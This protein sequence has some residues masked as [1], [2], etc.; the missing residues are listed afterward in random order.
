MRKSIWLMA[1]IL[2]VMTGVSTCQSRQTPP[3]NEEQHARTYFESLN[4]E[5]PEHAVQT[6]A[7]AF[8]QEDFMTVYLVLDAEAQRQLRIENAQTFTWKHLVGEAASQGFGNELDIEAIYSS[9]R[10]F[11]YLFDQLMLYAAEKN[12]LLIDLRGDL[13]I[14]RS[15]S[16]KLPESRQSMDVIAAVDDV[17]GEVLFRTVKDRENRW[18]VYKVSAPNEGVNSWPSTSLE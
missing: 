2:V 15:E 10:D 16:S 8:Q 6:F 1:I 3:P 12:D 9:H 14:L 5:T 13:E 11:W 7:E 18:R 17:S 4:L